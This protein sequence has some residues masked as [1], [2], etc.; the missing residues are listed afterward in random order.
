MAEEKEEGKKPEGKKEQPQKKE[1]AKEGGKDGTAKEGAAKEAAAKEG[2]AKEV[3]AKEDDAKK[4]AAKEGT[5]KEATSKEGAAKAGAAK[6]SAAKEEAATKGTASEGPAEDGAAKKGAAPKEGESN[7][8]AA[9][10]KK[11]G[12]AK[13]A[14]E[15]GDKKGAKKADAGAHGPFKSHKHKAAFFLAI[16]SLLGKIS[17]N[18][19]VWDEL[20]ESGPAWFFN[21]ITELSL[22]D[23][24]AATAEHVLVVLIAAFQSL[25][26]VEIREHF[27]KRLSVPLYL[28]LSPRRLKLEIEAFPKLKKPIAKLQKQVAADKA[29]LAGE[30]TYFPRIVTG[31]LIVLARTDALWAKEGPAAKG[32]QKAASAFVAHAELCSRY[33]EFFTD[34]LGQMPTRRFSHA[35]LEDVN[36]LVHCKMMQ[37]SSAD[38]PSADLFRKMLGLFEGSLD[39]PVHNQTAVA[40]TSNDSEQQHC[41]KATVFQRVAYRYYSD[42]LR[43]AAMCNLSVIDSKHQLSQ[44]VAKLSD[45]SLAELCEKLCLLDKRLYEKVP[46][47]REYLLQIILTR[48]TKKPD[49]SD[50]NT[51]P[52]Y[53]DENL[54]WDESRIPGDQ[55]TGASALALPKLNL[56]FLTIQDY[57]LRNFKL[58]QLES[59]YE[60]RE[61]IKDI[62]AKMRPQYHEETGSVT[63]RGRHRMAMPCSSME[64]IKVA[65]PPIGFTRPAEVRAELHMNLNFMPYDHVQ[66]EW[67]RMG[68][69][70]VLILISFGPSDAKAADV[71]KRYGVTSVRGCEI[72][73][74][75][76]DDGNVSSGFDGLSLTG[77]NRHV[78]VFLDPVAYQKDKNNPATENVYD[79][80]T[81]IMRRRPEENNFKAVLETIR[82]LMHFPT[83]VPEWLHDVFLGYGDADSAHYKNIDVEEPLPDADKVVVER[84]EDHTDVLFEEDIPRVH[85]ITF[86]PAQAE[87]IT[88]ANRH[89]LCMVVGPP[90]T[91]KTDVA[92]QII[93][94]LYHSFPNQITLV[95][96]HSN[97]ALNDIFSKVIKKDIDERY[98]LRLGMG[99]KELET[100]KD[101]SR[102]G[103]V[104]YMLERRLTLLKKVAKMCASIGVDEAFADTCESSEHFFSHHMR[105]R[106]VRFKDAIPKEAGE[107]TARW[108]VDHFPFTKYFD[109]TLRPFWA[110]ATGFGKAME[111]AEKGWAHFEKVFDELG[112]ARA[113]E[114]LRLAKD[115]GNYLLCKQ[116]KVIAMTCTHAALKRRDFLHLGF[117]YDNIIMEESAQILEIETFVPM[118]LQQPLENGES[119]LKRVVLIGDH[120]QL[121]PVVKNPTFQKYCHMDQPMFTRFIKLG[122]PHIELNAQGRMRS[123]LG[124][125]FRWRYK[126]LQDL[127]HVKQVSEFQK[128][129]AGFTYTHQFIDVEGKETEPQE[130]FYQNLIEA[131]IVV[132]TYMYMRLLG[133]PASKITLLS[134]YRGQNHLLQDVLNHRC[135][136]ESVYGAHPRVSTV[137]KFQGQQNDFILLSLVRTERVGH[138]RDVRRLVVALSRARLGLYVFGKLDLFS[139]VWELRKSFEVLKKHPT[140]LSLNTA[141]VSF[142]STRASGDAGAEV[143]TVSDLNAMAVLVKRMETVVVGEEKKRRSAHEVLQPSDAQL[144]Y[145]EEQRD[146]FTQ[147]TK[148]QGPRAGWYFGTGTYG[149][150]YYKDPLSPEEDEDGREAAPG[151]TKR[152]GGDAGAPQAEPPAKKKKHGLD[153][154]ARREALRKVKAAQ[155]V[156]RSSGSRQQPPKDAEPPAK[157]SKTQPAEPDAKA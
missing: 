49:Y 87:A 98:L 40:M 36:V 3:V 85:D 117:R 17:E 144:A 71:R 21:T 12:G 15:K 146:T 23:L 118:M 81:L 79:S 86:S 61:D 44:Y 111:A 25:E 120:N 152:A 130:H 62:L 110:G 145:E 7:A 143:T 135:P 131:E 92:V 24:P 8:A 72:I 103:R 5:A 59:T 11:E 113:F 35:Y 124:D 66:L 116:A 55:F 68:Q 151:K 64:V 88:T 132:H 83:V 46:L 58:M 14:D 13:K 102:R 37:F 107:R 75:R 32:K 150:G 43:D 106:W 73:D 137:D 147:A 54:L 108:V 90:G 1:A 52:V 51:V 16:E 134:T 57:L 114:L 109:G 20:I 28:S 105:N 19:D 33:L 76:D 119:R 9:P 141:E 138:L 67:D 6:E 48:H 89:G 153:E 115:R 95:I 140:K 142:P 45:E 126:D 80:F 128:A 149:L 65:P 157:L 101:F 93:S 42:K 94:N 112:D 34:L 99:E 27:L 121:P 104:N 125:L 74:I 70:D 63:F 2:A 56:Q 96:T 50:L 29:A 38:N 60:I 122:V 41:G 10:Q 30:R 78:R 22:E 39:F 77:V 123:E 82:D 31:F 4:G 100:D 18:I 139:N 47:S 136:E 133:Y 156:A 84:K 69:H 91:G 97:A 154:E 127:P 53:P 148:W 129:N 155:P 26:K